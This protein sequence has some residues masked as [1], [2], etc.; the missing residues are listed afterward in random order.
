MA[1]KPTYRPGHTVPQSGIYG[2][3]TGGR[4]TNEVTSV[5][6]E[7]FPPGQSAGTTYRIVRPTR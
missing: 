7:P 6:G 2:Q 5:Q 3:F 4:L 1:S